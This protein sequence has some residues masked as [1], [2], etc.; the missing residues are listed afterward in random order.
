MVL[1]LPLYGIQKPSFPQLLP[2]HVVHSW[3]SWVPDKGISGSCFYAT[4]WDHSIDAISGLTGP[5]GQL[6][7]LCKSGLIL[8]N[9][10][11]LSY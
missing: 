5:E 9:T 1:C 3:G 8:Q 6:S 10:S 11:F 7:Q 4:K 2:E